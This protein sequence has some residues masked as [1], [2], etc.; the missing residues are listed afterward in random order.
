MRADEGAV[1]EDGLGRGQEGGTDSA[2]IWGTTFP[3]GE[4]PEQ[5]PEVR[6]GACFAQKAAT[7]LKGLEWRE[8]K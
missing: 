5:G 8:V 3:E 7:G 2:E 6:E 4:Q 1:G